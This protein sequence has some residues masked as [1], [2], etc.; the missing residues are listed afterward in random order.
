M[1]IILIIEDFK[2]TPPTALFFMELLV[3]LN[4]DVNYTIVDAVTKAIFQVLV[5]AEN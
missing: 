5:S 1:G 2:Y 3:G 4:R